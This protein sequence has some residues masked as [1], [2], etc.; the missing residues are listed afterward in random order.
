VVPPVSALFTDL[1][2]LKMGQAYR[3]EGMEEAGTFSLFVRSLP[4]ERNFLLAAGLA[5]LLEALEALRFDDD[6]LAYLESLGSFSRDYLD[7]L[8][9]FRFEGDVWAVPEG[10]P[11][12]AEEPLLEVV[13]P[14]PQAQLVETLVMNQVHSATVLA[15]K[16]ARVVLAAGGRPVVDFGARRIHGTDTGVKS[17]RAYHLAG[18][19][20]TSNVLAGR[21]Y[22]VPVS[23]TMAHSY[24]EAHDDE[25]EA[26]RAFARE[27]P[28]TILLV[29]TYDTLGG[30]GQVTRLARELGDDFRVRGVR[31]DSGD[32]AELSLATRR[33]LDEAGLSRVEIFASG[34]LDERTIAELVAADRPI[35][36]FGVGTDMGVSSDAPKLDMAYKLTAYAGRGRMK[37]SSGKRTL[38]GRKQVFRREREG[39]IL[40]DCIARADEELPGRPLLRRVMR[41]G[42]VVPEAREDLDAGRE[43]ARREIAGLPEAVR[44]LDPAEP[45]FEVL[46]SRALRQH[47]DEVRERLRKEQGL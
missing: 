12:F 23:G 36:G 18:V 26:F 24:V 7:S 8:R 34:G 1:Y 31:L 17:A 40:C 25:Y 20:A 32:L 3:A 4:P 47:V 43:R 45:P 11:V 39:R 27:F 6:D 10:T 41:A 37:L 21:L 13:A 9:D 2:Q 16:A 35:D 30:V 22:G 38:P 15:S 5:P 42:R 19:A 46:L 29:D 28:D 44:S 14:A 33:M